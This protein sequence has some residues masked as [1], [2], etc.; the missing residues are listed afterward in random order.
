MD[1]LDEGM[2]KMRRVDTGESG[3]AEID[4]VVMLLAGIGQQLKRIAD[5]GDER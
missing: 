3:A 5:Q 4:I 1:Y 2:E